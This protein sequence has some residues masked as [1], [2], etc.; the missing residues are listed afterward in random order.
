MIIYKYMASTPNDFVK[1]EIAE[2]G[3]DYVDEMF[4]N[5]YEP[6]L[7]NGVWFWGDKFLR[8]IHATS[9]NSCDVLSSDSRDLSLTGA[10]GAFGSLTAQ[11]A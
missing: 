6:V 10:F 2:W 1:H 11:A 9:D 7:E 4:A 5:G 3:F 8:I